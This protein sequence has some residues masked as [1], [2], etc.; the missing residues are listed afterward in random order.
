MVALR[1]TS[2]VDVPI[3]DAIARPKLVDPEGEMVQSAR[4]VG[5]SFG[6]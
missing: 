5:V 2:I 6:N 4:S 3:A 1:G